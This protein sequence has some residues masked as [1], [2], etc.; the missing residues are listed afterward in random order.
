MG[1]NGWARRGGKRVK[2]GRRI[3]SWVHLN[4]S[5]VSSLS[6]PGPPVVQHYR[7]ETEGPR[8]REGGVERVWRERMSRP[9]FSSQGICGLN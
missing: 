8:C 1:S 7:G 3:P 2:E 9:L 4:P 5:C 6:P